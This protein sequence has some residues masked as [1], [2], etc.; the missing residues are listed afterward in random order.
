MIK[1][2]WLFFSVLILV[3]CTVNTIPKGFDE[4]SLTQQA[5]TLVSYLNADQS[6]EVIKMMRDD[7]AQ[8]IRAEDLKKVVDDK[9]STVGNFETYQNIVISDVKDPQ[10]SE[11]YALVIVQAKH[12]SGLATYTLSFDTELRC[13][14]LYL[15]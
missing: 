4:E 9:V 3:G 10:T 2:L 15:K 7:V 12:T 6:E 1:K 5:K 13:V 8:M 14:G 11:V